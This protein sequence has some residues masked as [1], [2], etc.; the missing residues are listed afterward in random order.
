MENI[1]FNTDEFLLLKEH[2]DNHRKQLSD[3]EANMYKA[4]HNKLNDYISSNAVEYFC[5]NEQIYIKIDKTIQYLYPT[6]NTHYYEVVEVCYIKG[7]VV[8][9]Q[10]KYIDDAFAPEC[11]IKIDTKIR[12]IDADEFTRV[13]NETC[14]KLFHNEN[15]NFEIQFQHF[16]GIFIDYVIKDY[17]DFFDDDVIDFTN[18]IEA[19]WNSMY[20]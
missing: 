18:N 5:I 9:P 6:L 4:W 11:N 7:L 15:D 16:P 14:K 13:L 8:K 2:I 10:E 20:S 3:M 1:Y 17:K 19:K 12:K